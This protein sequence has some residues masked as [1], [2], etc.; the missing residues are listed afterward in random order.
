MLDLIN[1]LP[2]GARVLD[3]GSG[4][5]SFATTRAD[6]LIVRLDYEM[7]H[8]LGHGSY[9]LA[10]A[11]NSPFTAHCFDLIISNHSLEHF[12]ALD[13]VLGEIGR[14]LK[15]GGVLY[16]AV[17]DAGTLADRIYRWLGRGGGHVN[18][19]RHP[20]EVSGRIERATGL[21]HRRTTTLF[22]SFSFLNR[23]NFVTRPP[24]RIALFA[25]GNE[26]FLAVTLWIL[27]GIDRRFGTRL[28]HYGWSF[29]FGNVRAP[30]SSEVWINVCVR[31]GSGH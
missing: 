18:A 17:P 21:P 30:E 31:C 24:R 4:P 26:R 23:N 25:Y 19:F 22:S 29:L 5:G 11:A 28:S 2:P 16:V 14:L 20:A 27:R 10:D 15:P 9:V 12:T 3:L 7:P 6:L 13:A 8:R 1:R